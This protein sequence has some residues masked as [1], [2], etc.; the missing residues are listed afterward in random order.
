M[1]NVALLAFNGW[2]E[3]LRGRFLPVAVLFGAVIL[4]LSLLLGVLA[5][6]QELRVLLDFGLAFL[7]FL[8]TAA[9]AYTAATGIL[10]ELE[11]KTVYLVLVRPVRRGEYLLGRYLGT[12]AA[13]LSA[14]AA[15]AAVHLSLL[16]W[17]GWGWDWAYLGA[18]LGVA[19][20]L[21]VIAA[22]AGLLALVATSALSALTMTAVAWMLGH[23]VP[24]MR[25]LIRRSA[26]GAAGW[27]L[28]AA[29]WLL[30]DLSLLNFR[31]RL[32]APAAALPA[33]PWGPALLYVPLY[34]GACLALAWALFRRREL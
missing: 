26:E 23:F 34:A 31:D 20:K 33:E 32:H 12:V 7:E 1:R 8:A 30:P 22:V 25:L 9:V 5:A 29:A 24:E 6:D 21:G 17:K 4:Y 18:L 11:T 15:M 3:Q 13:G 28:E 2:R 19:L 16:L 10:Q 27:A 14:A